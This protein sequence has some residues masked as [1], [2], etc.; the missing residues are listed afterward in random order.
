MFKTMVCISLS[1]R[2]LNLL[3]VYTIATCLIFMQKISNAI[4]KQKTGKASDPDDIAMEAFIYGNRRLSVHFDL[5]FI[6]SALS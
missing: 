2:E 6:Y 4:V 5:Q 3:L 1:S